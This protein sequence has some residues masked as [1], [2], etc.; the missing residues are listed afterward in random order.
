MSI[1]L[2]QPG[3]AST[4]P[5]KIRR[6]KSRLIPSVLLNVQLG[7]SSRHGPVSPV[8]SGCR[9]LPSPRRQSRHDAGL[10]HQALGGQYSK[11][12]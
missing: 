7:Q 11:L 4:E 5:N 3:S 1:A 8:M 6:I 10:P 9:E 2:A 12:S